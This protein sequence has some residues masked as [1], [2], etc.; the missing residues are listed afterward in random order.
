MLTWN[1]ALSLLALAALPLT[2]CTEGRAQDPGRETPAAAYRSLTQAFEARDWEGYVAC[3]HDD[4][5]DDMARE[6]VQRA[7]YHRPRIDLNDVL[8]DHGLPTISADARERKSGGYG[9]SEPGAP[10]LGDAYIQV[11]RAIRRCTPAEQRAVAAELLAVIADADEELI[12]DHLDPGC[13]LRNVEVRRG[14]AR[15]RMRGNS[16]TI[17]FQ[18]E[19]DVWFVCLRQPSEFYEGKSGSG[20][21]KT[22]AKSEYRYEKSGK[23]R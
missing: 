4:S 14:V 16:D 1:R 8:E 21:Y 17:Y 12:W 7:T 10:D 2:G 5:V 18:R 23:S 9:K 3:L 20:R 22:E 13:G 6:L 11:S 19:D 15:A